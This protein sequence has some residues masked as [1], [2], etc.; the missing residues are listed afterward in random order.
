MNSQVTNTLLMVRPRNFQGNAQTAVNN[1]FQ[2]L[3]GKLSVA[4]IQKEALREFDLFVEK[5]LAKGIEVIVIEDSDHPETP[6]A[7]FPNN[8]IS[9][10][11]SGKIYTYPMFAENRRLERRDAV[12]NQIDQSYEVSELI[13]LESWEDK[14]HFLEGTGSLVFER[15]QKIAYV[16]LSDRA[17]IPVI[18][19]FEEKSGYRTI[20]FRANHSVNGKRMPVYHTN[21]MMYVGEGFAVI[22]L[23]SIDDA[24]EREA[25]VSSLKASRKEIIAI[26]EKQ[27]N[28]FAGNGLQ[29]CNDRGDR[30]IVMS[31]RAYASLD[32]NQQK[33][34]EKNGE[35]IHSPLN[36]IEHYGGGSARCMMA[37]IFLR[38]KD[39]V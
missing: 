31:G 27:V 32:Q 25:V 6:D 29:V 33:A 7:I 22:C 21:V 30:F 19:D 26:T 17:H 39:H 28:S 24:V 13:R 8:W 38:K 18:K 36:T 10:H 11:Q 3:G 12:I 20:T 35:I 9:F 4:E 16:A 5:L 1:Y 14:G 23:D 37:E 34:L 2:N 15:L